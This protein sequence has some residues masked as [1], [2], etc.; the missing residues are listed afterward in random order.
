MNVPAGQSQAM[1]NQT[2]YREAYKRLYG[3]RLFFARI[4]WI[5]IVVPAYALFIAN[6]PAYFASLHL[7]HVPKT[8]TF[9]IQLTSR[10]IALLQSWGLSLDFYATCLLIITLLFQF[11]YALIGLLI[12]WRRSD[13]LIAL[14]T[15]F[16][17]MMLPFGFAVVTLQGLSP[18]WYWVIALLNALGNASIMLC[19]YLIPDG[20]FVPGWARWLALLMLGYWAMIALFPSWELGQSLLSLLLFCGFIVSTLF[21]QVYRYRSVSTPRQR[22]QTKWLVFGT[23]LAV[24]GNIGARLLYYF[25]L[26]PLFHG[27][28][29]ASALEITL[30]MFALLMIPATFGITIFSSHLWDIDVLINRTLVYS[31][32]TGILAMVYIVCIILLQMLLREL[33]SQTNDVAIVVSTLMVAA[34][35]QPLRRW[36]QQAIDRRFYRRKYDAVRTIEKFSATLRNEVDLN[37]LREDLLAV[38]EETMQPSHVSLWL[39]SPEQDRTHNQLGSASNLFPK[40]SKKG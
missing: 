37:R 24:G 10:D 30:I 27:S 13:Y 36:I 18:A 4:V 22:Q 3:H 19:G 9:S 11:C 5:A 33:I 16:S 17:L 40:S 6:I 35:F 23:T 2:Q 38:V 39:R 12:F 21:V 31:T 7:L 26:L 14:L 1:V 8:E 28:S 25:V 29:F 20:R 15:S 34:L 32:L